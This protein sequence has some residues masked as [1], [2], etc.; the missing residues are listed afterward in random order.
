MG[1]SPPTVALAATAFATIVTHVQAPLVG[2]VRGLLDDGEEP[3]DVVQEVFVDA[4]RAVGS[5]AN[6]FVEGDEEAS[7]RR[8]L[9]HVAYRRAVSVVRHRRVIAWE[10][11]DTANPSEPMQRTTPVSFDDQIAEGDALRAALSTLEPED[12]ACVL[13]VAVHDFKPAEIEQMLGITSDAT[14]KRLSRAMQRLLVAYRGRA[15]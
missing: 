8:W 15:N 5:G 2:L 13:L 9:F 10:S 7:A 14:R 3:R 6:S 1:G 12:A 4:W 11:L